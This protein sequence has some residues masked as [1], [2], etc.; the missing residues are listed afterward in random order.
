[1]YDSLYYQHHHD[2]VIEGIIHQADVNDNR[3]SNINQIRSTLSYLDTLM[4]DG[5]I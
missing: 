1:M 3:T 5:V 4:I 2:G